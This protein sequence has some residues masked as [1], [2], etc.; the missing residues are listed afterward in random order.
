MACETGHSGP[1]HD[2]HD[3]SR[4]H[5]RPLIGDGRVGLVSWVFKVVFLLFRSFSLLLQCTKAEDMKFL[6]HRVGRVRKLCNVH[7]A[8]NKKNDTGNTTSIV[9]PNNGKIS[10]VAAVAT[11]VIVC[12]SGKSKSC[13]R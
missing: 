2:H 6:W 12:S 4:R 11:M 8:C 5:Q 9:S 1:T 7:A 10:P 13:M 3:H